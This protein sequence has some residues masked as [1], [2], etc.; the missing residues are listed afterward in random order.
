VKPILFMLRPSFPDAKVGPGTFFCPHTATVEGLL[1]IYPGLR[2]RLDV[3][4]VDFARPRHAV[5]AELGE[6]HQICPVLVLP[7]GWPDAPASA[8]RAEGRAFFVGA[9]E[10]AEFLALWAGIDRPHP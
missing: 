4:H 7:A 10:I 8:R 6:A 5:I 2:E 9:T 3:R 1:A